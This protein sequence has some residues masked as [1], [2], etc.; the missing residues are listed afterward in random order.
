MK[1]TDQGIHQ[2]TSESMKKIAD[3]ESF[4][5]SAGMFEL[6][7]TFARHFIKRLINEAYCVVLRNTFL[8]VA[9]KNPKAQ[10]SQVYLL[11]YLI[12]YLFL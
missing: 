6:T 11:N 1:F 10:F 5:N 8:P 7:Q 12:M 4:G 9:L 2:H 3:P